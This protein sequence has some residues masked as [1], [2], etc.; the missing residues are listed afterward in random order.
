MFAE[1]YIKIPPP[2]LVLSKVVTADNVL[3]NSFS[4]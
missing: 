3:S 1:V 4:W 2:P